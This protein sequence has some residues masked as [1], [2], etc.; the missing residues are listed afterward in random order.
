[1][2]KST[3]ALSITTLG[4]MCLATAAPFDWT[5]NTNTDWSTASNWDPTNVPNLTGIDNAFVSGT[6]VY[7]AA[8]GDFIIS[9]GSTLTIQNGGNWSQTNGIAW[10]KMQGGTLTIES[11]GIFDTGTAQNLE[12]PGGGTFN[13]SGTFNINTSFAFGIGTNQTL[14]L[15]GGDLTVATGDFIVSDNGVFNMTGGSAIFPNHVII[16]ADTS[17]L[18]FGG[19]TTTITNELKPNAG[20]NGASIGGGATV[21]ATLIS[22]DGGDTNSLDVADGRLNISNGTSFNGIFTA[23]GDDYVNL[24]T[25]S[26]EVFI[27]NLT[28]GGSITLL[29]DGRLRFNDAIGNIVATPLGDGYLF[30]AIPEP[31]T[32]ALLFGAMTLSVLVLRRRKA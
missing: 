4:C 3:L 25:I 9:T 16:N 12:R 7:N 2:K 5:G 29:S 1:M 14:N 13:V 19:G 28:E 27:D 6:T 11:G 31:S 10:I 24:T 15:T 20:L 30:T 22:F 23:G 18:S 8:N 21:N 26:S 32:Y 17:T